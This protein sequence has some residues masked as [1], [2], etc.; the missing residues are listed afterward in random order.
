MEK[1]IIIA[2]IGIIGAIFATYRQRKLDREREYELR[3]RDSK[4]KQYN[5][6]LDELTTL[7]KKLYVSNG[8]I[9]DS[10]LVGMRQLIRPLTS[11]ASTNVLSACLQLV[12]HAKGF[13]SE[14]K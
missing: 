11:W 10:N 9:S 5:K 4:E 12:T 14:K 2:L 7:C 8:K 3:M 6:V 13:T 1:E